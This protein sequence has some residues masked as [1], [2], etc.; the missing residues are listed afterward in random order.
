MTFSFHSVQTF[1]AGIIIKPLPIGSMGLE[2]LPT[3]Y[4]KKSPIHVGKYTIPMHPMGYKGI[5][6]KQP[7]MPSERL[8]RL[9]PRPQGPLT[10]HPA[11][12]PGTPRSTTPPGKADSTLMPPQRVPWTLGPRGGGVKG[13]WLVGFG[14]VGRY[15]KKMLTHLKETKMAM[16]NHHFY[17]WFVFV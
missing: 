14:W 6:M 8:Q 7:G 2:Y 16:E 11:V 17:K 12:G 15:D 5:P 13:G 3:F 1:R 4:H 9:G 10:P